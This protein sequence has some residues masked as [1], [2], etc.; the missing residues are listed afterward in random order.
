MAHFLEN[1]DSEMM[2]LAENDAQVLQVVAETVVLAAA[3]LKSAAEHIEVFEP[4]VITPDT[5]DEAAE[6]ITALDESGDEKLQKIASVFDELLLTIAAQPTS[7]R[8]MRSE[9]RLTELKRKYEENRKLSR[10]N[11][12]IDLAEKIVESS[13]VITSKGVEINDQ[14][15]STRTCPLHHGTS[16]IR[17]GDHI[18][19]CPL[20]QAIYNYDTGFTIEQNGKTVRVPGGDVSL[21]TTNV[22]TPAHSLFDSRSGRLGYH[23]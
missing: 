4:S 19:Q 2:I 1:P 8:G 12:K 10:E 7:E 5:L 23:Q 3:L 9:L 20:D 15:L 22:V 17:V 14:P 11:S 13:P 21:Q 18:W 16:V 6:I